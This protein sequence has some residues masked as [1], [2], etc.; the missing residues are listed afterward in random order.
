MFEKKLKYLISNGSSMA[1]T[2]GDFWRS[3]TVFF[4]KKELKGP[5]KSVVSRSKS[6][7]VSW[8]L[9]YEGFE[10]AKKK[11][12]NKKWVKLSTS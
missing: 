10:S 7:K 5:P 11:I 9:G 12:D 3:W 2:S 8:F 4:Q 1:N 6:V